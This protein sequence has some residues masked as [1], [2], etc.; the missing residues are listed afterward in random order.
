MNDHFPFALK[1]LLQ[2]VVLSVLTACATNAPAILTPESNSLPSPAATRSGEATTI[3]AAT[4]LTLA[5]ATPRP[6]ARVNIVVNASERHQVINGFGATLVPFELDGFYRAH[7]SSQPMHVVVSAEQ[8]QAMARIIHQELGFSRVRLSLSG[9]EPENDNADPNT[10]DWS[11][12]VWANRGGDLMGTDPFAD[13]VSLT[14]PLGLRTWFTTFQNTGTGEEW[15]RL[16]NSATLDSRLV[17]E[18]VEHVLAVAIHFRDLGIPFEYMALQNEPAHGAIMSVE[19]MKTVVAKLGARLRANG[20]AARL[21]IADDIT[22]ASALEYA[23]PIL[24]DP[25]TRQ[26]VGAIAYHSYDGRYDNYGNLARAVQN[27]RPTDHD[28]RAELRS[29]AAQYRV[30]L[31]MTEVSAM[32]GAQTSEFEAALLRA[33]HALDELTLYDVA[34]FDQM[35]LFFIQRPAIEESFFYVRFNADGTLQRYDVSPYGYAL[36]HFAREVVADSARV[37]AS[38]SDPLVRVAAFERPDGQVVVVLINNR[39]DS[40]TASVSGLKNASASLRTRVSTAAQMWQSGSV[41]AGTTPV[42]IVLPAH[43]ITTLAP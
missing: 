31:W 7:D 37:E 3:A 16:P 15:L 13:Y 22:P 35:L 34:A 5:T 19:Y 39:G 43:S 20:L 26:Y 12:F 2:L 24:S 41:T 33:N 42:N 18:Y 30:P 10:F 9:F 32:R 8:R 17:D 21:V 6:T 29:L 1:R 4:A 14:R 38:S 40:V 25:N 36:A 28:A 27:P 23:R 11:K